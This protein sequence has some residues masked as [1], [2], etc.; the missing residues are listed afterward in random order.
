MAIATVNV[1]EWKWEP[2][3]F[4]I[5]CLFHDLGAMPE[6]IRSTKL[7]FEFHGVRVYTLNPCTDC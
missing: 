1:P 5:T 6:S 7:S 3:T 2:E 4:Y